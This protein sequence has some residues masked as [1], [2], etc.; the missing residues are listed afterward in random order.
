MGL[1]ATAVKKY[2]IEYGQ[3][4]GFNYDVDG[5]YGIIS[6]FCEDFYSGDVADPNVIWEINKAEFK[7][8]IETIEG[9]ADE[10]YDELIGGYNK[11]E[12]IRNLNGYL[13]ETPRNSDYVRIAWL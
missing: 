9:L 1:W 6:Q 5:L 7:E 3:T 11:E 12:L 2:E 13:A 10:D 8:M 4:Q